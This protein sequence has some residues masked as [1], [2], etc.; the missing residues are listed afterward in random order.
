M[1]HRYL[2]GMLL[3]FAATVGVAGGVAAQEVAPRANAQINGA[4]DAFFAEGGT[5]EKAAAMAAGIDPA[6]YDFEHDPATSEEVHRTFVDALAAGA[7]PDQREALEQFLGQFT[8]ERQRALMRDG[9]ESGDWSATNLADVIAGSVLSGY[10][11]IDGRET[12]AAQDE[13]VRDLFRAAL[14]V[15]AVTDLPD[16]DR[17]VMA[18]TLLLSTVA[19]LVQYEQAQAGQGEVGPVRDAARQLLQ[20]FGLDPAFFRLGPT[21][22]EATPEM[23]KVAAGELTMEQAFPDVMAELAAVGATAAGDGAAAD[24]VAEPAV[25]TPAEPVPLPTLDAPADAEVP[26]GPAPNPLGG[27]GGATNP[28]GAKPAASRFAATFAGDGVT[29]ALRDGPDGLSGEI[30]YGGE[31]YPATAVEGA[32]G[33]AGRFVASGT[34]FDFTARPEGAG[35]VMETGGGRYRLERQGAR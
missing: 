14:D 17:Q 2:T 18:E 5:P 21:G 13:P 30:T 3:A 25:A 11:I 22:L 8:I 6:T 15:P 19:L 7:A 26:V 10:A 20:G 35:V 32:D 9:F 27:D 31:R 33:L 29:L 28:L 16:R 34:A 1:I 24:A 23:A 12:V 4:L